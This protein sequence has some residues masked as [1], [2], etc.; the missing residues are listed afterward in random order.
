MPIYEYV[1]EK[2]GS[3]FEHLAFS[4]KEPLPECPQCKHKKVKKIIS[5][6]CVRPNGIASGSGGFAPPACSPSG[7]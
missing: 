2:C 4:T 1:C 3:S 7:G 6:G 5:A